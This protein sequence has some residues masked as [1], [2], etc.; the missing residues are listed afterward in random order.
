MDFGGAIKRRI[1]DDALFNDLKE[2]ISESTA[3]DEI[4]KVQAVKEKEQKI[5]SVAKIP[6]RAYYYAMPTKKHKYA[7]YHIYAP[8]GITILKVPESMLG[9]NVLGTANLKT[10]VI[11]ILESLQG[12]AFDEVKRH[13]LN[14]LK[15]PYLGE[16]D[17]RQKTRA[18]L[19]HYP[20]YH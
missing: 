18:E 9:A 10:N 4:Q 19:A 7:S 12:C 11:H 8:D 16:W 14:H 20:I 3:E 6:V 2:F 5:K 17:I 1:L 15:F 13:E